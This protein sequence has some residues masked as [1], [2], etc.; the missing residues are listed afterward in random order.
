ME[1]LLNN[2]EA[3]NFLGVSPH[4]LRRFVALGLIPFTKIGK[5]LV[6]FRLEDLEAYLN[7]QTVQVRRR[8]AE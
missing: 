1:R 3:A 7:R 2:T 8:E 5:R 4:S 6:R